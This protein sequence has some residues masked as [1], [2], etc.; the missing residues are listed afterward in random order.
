LQVPLGTY[1]GWNETTTGF[2]AGSG[3]SFIGGFVP[4]AKTRAERLKAGDTR[5]SLEERYGNRDGFLASVRAA[6]ARQQA[7]GWLL[8]RDAERL[9]RQAEESEVLR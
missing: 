3:C 2:D 4:F 8:P 9:L 5:A 6:V 1:L 7:A